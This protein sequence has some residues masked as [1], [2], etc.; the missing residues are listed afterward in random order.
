MHEILELENT[1]VLETLRNGLLDG[2]ELAGRAE[3]I[4]MKVQA[5][6]RDEITDTEVAAFCDDALDVIRE[7]TGR[8]IKYALWLTSKENLLET[9]WRW[10]NGAYHDD[11]LCPEPEE[12][13]IDAYEV[14]P[15][16]L[17]DGDGDGGMLY[18]YETCP[19][20]I[21]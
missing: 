21:N 14:G 15:V 19:Q 4:I 6:T 10:A 11:D 3:A 13:D 8:S 9:F 18:G 17:P 1:D 20:P 7:K 12:G 5:G 16:I 2:T